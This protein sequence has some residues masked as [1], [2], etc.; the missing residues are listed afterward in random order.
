MLNT[1]S[2]LTKTSF[3]ST[4]PIRKG[5]FPD[6]PCLLG[7]ESNPEKEHSLSNCA[8]GIN[9]EEDNYCFWKWIRRNSTEDGFMDPLLQ[10]EMSDLLGISGA[11]IYSIFR[12]ALEKIKDFPEY[13]DLE[14][15]FQGN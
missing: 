11:K 15:L 14:D 9:S 2:K 8:W 13:E 6:T 3:W 7:K 12:E 5:Y 4:C 10:H 1:P